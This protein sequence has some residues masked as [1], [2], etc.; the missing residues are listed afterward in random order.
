MPRRTDPFLET[1][2]FR[3][4]WWSGRAAS[5][6]VQRLSGCGHGW[7]RRA[8]AAAAGTHRSGS[9]YSPIGGCL[10]KGLRS[11]RALRDCCR[12]TSTWRSATSSVMGPTTRPT[13]A[14]NTWIHPTPCSAAAGDRSTWPCR[15]W[16]G[17]LVALAHAHGSRSCGRN[18]NGCCITSRRR[19]FAVAHD[20]ISDRRSCSRAASARSR[21]PSSMRRIIG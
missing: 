18:R 4:R 13:F 16:Q 9:T 7:P 3:I 14:C 20:S 19:S 12:N 1:T 11:R 15:C 10:A 17:S 6:C 5:P 2:S 21:M 8:T